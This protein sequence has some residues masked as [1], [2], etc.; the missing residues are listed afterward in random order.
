MP[1][2]VI[3]RTSVPTNRMYFEV[4]AD[5]PDALGFR[6]ATKPPRRRPLQNTGPGGIE[7]LA[8]PG[9]D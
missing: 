8:T 3:K 7:K 1:K 5:R 4:T 6:R 9:H 2:R